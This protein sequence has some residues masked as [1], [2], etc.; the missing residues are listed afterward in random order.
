MKSPTRRSSES[1]QRK[2]SH[3]KHISSVDTHRKCFLM[4]DHVRPFPSEA[5]GLIA[6]V[7]YS[8]L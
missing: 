7:I 1:D 4:A 6:F 5:S 2:P 3:L 8:R